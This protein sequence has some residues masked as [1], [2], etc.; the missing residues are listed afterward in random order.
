MGT[1]I[2]LTISISITERYYVGHQETLFLLLLLIYCR[3]KPSMKRYGLQLQRF[4]WK[5]LL[6]S[7][8]MSCMLCV[9]EEKWKWWDMKTVVRLEYA[10]VLNMISVKLRMRFKR[11]GHMN[12]LFVIVTRTPNVIPCLIRHVL[13]KKV[14]NHICGAHSVSNLQSPFPSPFDSLLLVFPFY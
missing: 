5:F 3:K 10:K 1:Q 11:N 14:L 12:P 13:S 7:F 4:A 2:T 8:A 6:C 9:C